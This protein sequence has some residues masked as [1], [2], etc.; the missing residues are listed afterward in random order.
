M[1]AYKPPPKL[2]PGFPEAVPIKPKTPFGKDGR[3]L[4]KRWKDSDGT[5]Y[6]WDYQHGT[7]E[8]YNSNGDH[9]GEFRPD[10]GTKIG[11]AKPRN[12]EP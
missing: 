7:V 6:E 1:C 5:I 9:Q 12:V 11:P 10:D 8:R 2:L 3:K 4:R